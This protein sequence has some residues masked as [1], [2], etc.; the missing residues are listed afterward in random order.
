[1][2]HSHGVYDVDAH[3]TIDV[4]TRKIVNLSAKS[5]LIQNDHNSERFTFEIPRCVD[6]HD[7]TLCDKV[8]IHYINVSP[9]GV[10]KSAGVYLVDDMAHST[11]LNDNAVFSWLVS[12]NAT[13]Y[14]GCLNFL[15]R[16]V[17]L[18]DDNT[19]EYAWHTDI[20]KGIKVKDGMNNGEAVA[21]IFSDV[22]EAWK[23]EAVADVVSDV[24]NELP[25][26]D[27]VAY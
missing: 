16:F 24:L 26:G 10:D 1:M 12:A 8:E 25:N 13:Q 22:L 11:S 14:S 9:N 3:F 5:N 18:A 15:I 27:E 19:I 4:N 6:G 21:A 2:S 23:R 7:M 20:Y 17:C